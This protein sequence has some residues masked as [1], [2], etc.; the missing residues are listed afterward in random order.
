MS[1]ART[2]ELSYAVGDLDVMTHLLER[3]RAGTKPGAHEDARR[4]ALVIEGGGMRGVYVGGMVRAIGRLGLRDTFDEVFAVSA[5]A[6]TGA[7][8][9]TNLTDNLAHVYYNDLA[10]GA[11]VDYR[12]LLT[13]RGPL[14]SLDFLLDTVMIERG[15]FDWDALIESDLPLHPIATDLD[16]LSAAALVGLH[17][18]DDWR[19]ALLASAR[20]PYW[21]GPPIELQGRRWVDGFVT[22]PL[23]VARAIDGGATHILVLRARGTTED[24]LP[25]TRVARPMRVHLNGLAPGLATVMAKRGHRHATSTALIRAPRRH[26]GPRILG[27]HPARSYGIKSLTCDVRRLRLAGE[28]G[29][30]AVHHAIAAVAR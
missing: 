6:F 7:G 30:A 25:P 23:P 19:G 5:G 8:L 9:A 1:L 11:F 10:V 21:A 20:I 18:A 13:R 22:D 26:D 2:D 29:E 16:T 15:G 14:V 27:L 28:A 24:Q 17:T 4:I 3:R 12:R